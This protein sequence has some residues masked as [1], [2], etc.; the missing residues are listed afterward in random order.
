MSN[1]NAVLLELVSI[2]GDIKKVRYR[3]FISLFLLTCRQYCAG[4]TTLSGDV[5][6]DE[7]VCFHTLTYEKQCRLNPF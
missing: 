7:M 4:T 1:N 3:F 6:C 2:D 5:G